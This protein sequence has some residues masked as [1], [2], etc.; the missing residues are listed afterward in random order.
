MGDGGLGIPYKYRKFEHHL[1]LL[2]MEYKRAY[3]YSSEAMKN[4]S[5]DEMDSGILRNKLG[6]TDQRILNEEETIGFLAAQKR[7]TDELT[8]RTKFNANYIYLIHRLALGHIYGFAGRPR[9]VNISKSG[10]R[11][12]L[13]TEIPRAM[14]YLEREYLSKLPVTYDDKDDLIKDI[15]IIHCELLYIHPF[16]EGNGRTS[17]IFADLMA[18]RAGFPLLDLMKFRQ[19]HYDA[20]VKALNQ[21]ENQN[22]KPMIEIIA[23]LFSTF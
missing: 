4:V 15:A 21:G 16:R 22:Y 10:H 20:Y 2:K 14:E 17:R 18:N 8:K 7:L 6:I 23:E 12:M 19:N 3:Q 1:I 9:E 11:F 5:Y 13:F